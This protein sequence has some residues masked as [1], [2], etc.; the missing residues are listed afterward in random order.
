[1]SGSECDR[2][3]ASVLEHA[4]WYTTISVIGL[5]G[6]MACGALTVDDPLY[7]GDRAYFVR[8]S[9]GLEFSVGDYHVGRITGKPG[10]GVA[11][12]VVEDGDVRGVVAGSIDLTTLAE[13][14][15]GAELPEGATFTVLDRDGRIVVRWPRSLGAAPDTVG[16]RAPS[17]FPSM[18]EGR[19]PVVVEGTDLYGFDRIYAVA[20][21]AAGPGRPQGYVAIG[22]SAAVLMDRVDEVTRSQ[23]RGLLVA[24]AILFVIAWL[25]GHYSLVRD[26]RADGS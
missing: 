3:L 22:T 24:A 1:M 9:S 16:T 4:P 19:R 2:Q 7:L 17:G 5:D 23:L 26:S 14:A 6:Y 21:L 18:P 20:A 13:H 8:A 10:V 11:L 25:V 12:P 15:T